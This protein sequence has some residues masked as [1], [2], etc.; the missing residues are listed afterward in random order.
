MAAELARR[1]DRE[2]ILLL[3]NSEVLPLDRRKPRRIFALGPMAHGLMNVCFCFLLP[4]PGMKPAR[5]LP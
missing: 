3:E 1:I 5:S 2:S 4:Y